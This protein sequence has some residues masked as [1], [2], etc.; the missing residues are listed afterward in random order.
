MGQPLLSS[1]GNQDDL[2]HP[3]LRFVSC[4][5]SPCV[6]Y[7]D[8]YRLGW[9]PV[10]FFTTIWVTEVYKQGHPE[11]DPTD[12]EVGSAAVRAGARSLFCQAVVGLICAVTIPFLVGSSG[13]AP[14]E[15]EGYTALNGHGTNGIPN[16]A[17]WKRSQEEHSSGSRV[18]RALAWA[19]DTIGKIRAGEGVLPLNGLTLMRIWIVA[20]F[21]FALAMFATL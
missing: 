15:E 14:P 13:V 16:S 7:S 5:C 2:H 18:A 8:K 3:V 10:L 1:A 17:T 11:L 19:K 21:W 6:S 4:P 9:Y 12:P 20:Q